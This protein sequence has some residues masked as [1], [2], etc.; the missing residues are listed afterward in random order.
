MSENTYWNSVLSYRVGRRRAIA[1]VAA[2]GAAALFLAACGSSNSKSS[3][4]GGGSALVAKAVDTIKQAKKGGVYKSSRRNDIDHSDPFFTTQAAPGTAEVYARLFRRAP[5]YLTSQPVDY[6]GDLADSWEFSPDKLQLTVKLKQGHWHNLPPVNGRAVEASDVVYTWGR[7]EAV[8]ANRGLLSNKISPAAPIQSITAV[9]KSTIAIKLAYPAATVIPLLSGNISGYLWILPTESENY[10][11]RRVTIGSGPWMVSEYTPSVSIK[12]KRNAGY[13]DADAILIDEYDQPI[14][15]EYAAALAQFKSG[16]IYGPAGV[17]GFIVNA[18][19]VL[20]TK[21]EVPMLNL[22]LEEPAAMSEFAFFGWNPAYGANTPFRDKRLRQAFSMSMDR[23]LWIDTFY[24]TDKFKAEGIDM[25]KPWN[26]VLTTNWPGWWLDPQGKDL[27]DAAKNFQFN[28]TEAKKLVAAAGLPATQVIKAQY[29]LTGYSADY[30]K[31]NEVVMNFAK[32]AGFN[33]V[34]SPVSFTTEWRPKVSDNN[35]DFEGISFRPDATAG[36]PHPVE[37]MYAGL[38][39]EAGA[40]YTGFFPDNSSWKMG[41]PRLDDILSK[42]R[43]EF[44]H[45]EAA[46]RHRGPAEDRRG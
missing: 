31:H 27:G 32:E 4:S 45:K 41:D 10:D 13:H 34:T 24:E 40:G 46:G 39:H 20:A 42:A 25:A 28:L 37:F 16:A 43:R 38:H 8:S 15:L 1:G 9:D 5:G 36:L 3:S 14:V 23:N 12:F 35:G 17:G 6:I 18:T 30:L 21:R 22:Y 2:G 19:D 11:P 7:L 33:M 44:D 26:T 29:P